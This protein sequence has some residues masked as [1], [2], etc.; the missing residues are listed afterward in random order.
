L[1]P[2]S[3]LA[4]SMTLHE[5]F[6]NAVKYGS[7]SGEAGK[8]II[9]WRRDGALLTLVWREQDGPPVAPPRRRG[10]GSRMIDALARDLSGAARLDL[11]LGEGQTS[12]EAADI[13]RGRGVPFAFLTGYGVQGVRP[14]LRDAPVLGKPVDPE[15][16]RR[17]LESLN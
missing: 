8:V 14:D 15:E 9:G 7:L 12:F 5:L 4:L 16:L 6:T 11:N 2:K 10:F 3:V 1:T 17:L 13:L